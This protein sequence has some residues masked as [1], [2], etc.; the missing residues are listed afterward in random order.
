GS[1]LR[2][3]V[4]P[5]GPD[6]V[7]LEGSPVDWKPFSG[8]WEGGS[9]L[10]PF[11]RPGQ[12]QLTPNGDLG[13]TP[14]VPYSNPADDFVHPTGNRTI[15]HNGRFAHPAAAPDNGLLVT[16]AIGGGSTNCCD[17]MTWAETLALISKDAGI[18]YIPL[19]AHST[20]RIGHIADDA[21]VV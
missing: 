1:L 16:Y 17:T 9:G 14:A 13:D 3:P 5:P 2:F 8:V 21:Q 12:F 15:T 19:E 6:F 7:H 4:D 11:G 18:W 20:R 10:V